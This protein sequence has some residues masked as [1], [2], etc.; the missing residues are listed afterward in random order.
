MALF[1]QHFFFPENLRG[2]K[3]T[4]C[5]LTEIDARSVC[6]IKEVNKTSC[7]PDKATV[8]LQSTLYSPPAQSH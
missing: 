4:Y 5:K 3:R 8:L 6:M 7:P 2:C 1:Q